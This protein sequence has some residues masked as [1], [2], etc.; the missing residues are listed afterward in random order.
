MYSLLTSSKFYTIFFKKNKKYFYKTIFPN[1]SLTLFLHCDIVHF[2][3]SSLVAKNFTFKIDKW[4]HTST[5]HMQCNVQT[6]GTYPPILPLQLLLYITCIRYDATIKKIQYN[7]N[8]SRQSLR[9]LFISA[10]KSSYIQLIKDIKAY[11][12]NI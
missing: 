11:K 8:N 3:L 12:I 10:C 9:I 1:F 5:Y 2:L 4:D 6:H 7:V